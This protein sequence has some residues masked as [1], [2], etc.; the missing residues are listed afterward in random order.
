MI[1]PIKLLTILFFLFVVFV[2]GTLSGVIPSYISGLTESVGMVEY[3]NHVSELMG[4]GSIS[5]EEMADLEEREKKYL[6]ELSRSNYSS[7]SFTLNYMVF[8][9]MF[10][11]FGYAWYRLGRI[12]AGENYIVKS[13]TV[14]SAGIPLFY[15]GYFYQSIIHIIA[16]CIGLFF[17]DITK[18][19]SRNHI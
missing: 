10:L 18:R 5:M 6:N 3:Q 17:F 9:V 2:Y 4:K 11:L 13:L 19:L 14:V 16:L 7:K 15:F 12:G 1:K 8:P